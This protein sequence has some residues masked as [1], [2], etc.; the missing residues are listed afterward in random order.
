MIR[1]LTAERIRESSLNID[2]CARRRIEIQANRRH[3][4]EAST[5]CARYTRNLIINKCEGDS[6]LF[7]MVAGITAAGLALVHSAASVMRRPSCAH[8][9]T[10]TR[11]CIP[12]S[13]ALFDPLEIHAPIVRCPAPHS[14]VP[15]FLAFFAKCR[16]HTFIFY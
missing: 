8:V 15:R 3:R 16:F 7:R 9:C 6:L 14:F 2:V 1:K 10:Y 12:D 11:T 5:D 13:V 4:V